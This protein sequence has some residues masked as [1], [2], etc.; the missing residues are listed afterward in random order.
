MNRR[1]FLQNAAA[2]AVGGAT[3]VRG[4]QASETVAAARPRRA[5]LAQVVV[6]KNVGQN[7]ANARRALE[8]AGEEKADFVLFP[9][10]FL[11]GGVRDVRQDEASAGMAETAQWCRKFAVIGLV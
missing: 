4:G 5:T 6:H 3:C 9:E 1:G 11:T 7:L 2:I 8:H 10:L